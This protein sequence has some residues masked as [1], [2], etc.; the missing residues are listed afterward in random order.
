MS[1]GDPREARGKIRAQR[2]ENFRLFHQ[3]QVNTA[4]QAR[5]HLTFREN[6]GLGNFAR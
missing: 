2:G 4:V 1:G 5:F 3:S 6:A